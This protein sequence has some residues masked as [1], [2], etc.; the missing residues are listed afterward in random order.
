MSTT[1]R[2]F[3]IDQSYFENLSISERKIVK[4]LREVVEKI[5]Q[6]YKEQ[7]KN[8]FYPK[9]VTKL[10]IEQASK[11]NSEIL[12]P[13]TIVEEKDGKLI[14]IPYHEKYAKDLEKLALEVEKAAELSDNPTFK[15]YLL[16]R[17]ASLRDGSYR[18]ADILWLNVKNSKIDFSIG[19]FERY[20]DKVLFLKR[21]FQAHVGI[22]DVPLTRYS[23]KIKETLYGSAKLS[24]EKFH[25]TQIPKKGVNILVEEVIASSGYL[26]EVL[27]SGEHF[28]SDLDIMQE[29]G[30]KIVL[31]SSQ[32]KLK[33]EK[34]HLPIF[35]AIFEKKFAQKYSKELL[36]RATIWTILLYEL[37]RQ[38][39][40]FSN[41]RERLQELYGPIDEANG[42]ASGIAHSKHLVVKGLIS[43]DELEAIIIIHIVWMFSDWLMNRVNQ[44][45]LNYTL[46]NAICLNTYISSGALKQQKGIYWPN[47]SKIFFEIE[48]LADRLVNLLRSGSYQDAER[49]IQQNANFTNF[50][51]I[52]TNL[53]GFSISF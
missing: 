7:L 27:F 6:V 1:Y 12:S 39:H 33:F 44:D 2:K 18:E 8:G 13:F 30:S 35:K 31:Y 41:A 40:K 25:S 46:G 42:F 14:A 47:F 10:E 9:G 50:K 4:I 23:E 24:L 26:A 28:P 36:Y 19:P 32:L 5:N 11:N 34:L 17:A 49:F 20:L 37:G 43:E 53:K 45:M 38:L 22:I 52:G 15:K 51:K 3:K 29:H 16:A 48:Y 21:S